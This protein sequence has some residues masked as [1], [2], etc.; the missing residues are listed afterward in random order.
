LYQ[1]PSS[2]QGAAVHT[3]RRAQGHGLRQADAHFGVPDGQ[4]WTRCW[5]PCSP[6]CWAGHR[7]AVHRAP[8]QAE[9]SLP[10]EKDLGGGCL[11]APPQIPEG[12]LA[13]C[14]DFFSNL[15]PK[16]PEALDFLKERGGREWGCAGASAPG[17]RGNQRDLPAEEDVARS[18]DDSKAWDS[19]TWVSPSPGS[20]SRGRDFVHQR[21][22]PAAFRC[23]GGRFPFLVL[24]RFFPRAAHLEGKSCALEEGAAGS[25]DLLAAEVLGPRQF[26]P[27]PAMKGG[28]G[29]QAGD[30]ASTPLL[31]SAVGLPAPALLSAQ[32]RAAR[33]TPS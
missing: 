6:R 9:R 13:K 5:I 2:R 28:P 17:G 19:K 8:G 30:G 22:Y 26:C 1:I 14:R 21:A 3:S 33:L 12:G 15:S 7:E 18:R 10:C 16:L 4:C 32:V 24:R 23:V 27:I 29:P 25:L 31:P 11:L 20:L